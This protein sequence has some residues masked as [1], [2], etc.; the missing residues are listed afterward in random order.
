VAWQGQSEIDI[1]IAKVQTS[2]S[3]EDPSDRRDQSDEQGQLDLYIS[4]KITH[5]N[6]NHKDQ[7]GRKAQADFKDLVA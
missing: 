5:M 1:Q 7:P 6:V 2:E 4:M 3:Y